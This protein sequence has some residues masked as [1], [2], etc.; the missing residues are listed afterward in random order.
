MKDEVSGVRCNCGSRRHAVLVVKVGPWA[1]LIGEQEHF[2]KSLGN[3][4]VRICLEYY[5]Y[6]MYICLKLEL[7][8]NVF[9]TYTVQRGL[10]SLVRD[11]PA[12][13][14]GSNSSMRTCFYSCA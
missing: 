8:T 11:L 1:G 7:R 4:H 3:V 10:S 9:T 12:L 14:I 5:T 2:A 13:G 6:V